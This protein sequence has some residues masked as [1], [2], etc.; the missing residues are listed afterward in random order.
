MTGPVRRLILQ[1]TP[2]CNIGCRYC[3]LPDRDTRQVMPMQVVAATAGLLARSARLDAAQLGPGLLDDQLE[4]RWH[5]GEPLTVPAAFY[6]QACQVLAD[7]LSPVTRPWFS[8]QTNGTLI[9]ASWCDLFLRR[10]IEVG[11]SIDGPAF[12]HDASRVTKRGGPTHARAMRGIAALRAAG[13]AFDVITVVTE[14]T[15]LHA[16]EY[17]DFMT[18]LRPR[19]IGLNPEETEGAHQSGLLGAS[20]F[21]ARYTEFLARMY[22]WQE[23]TGIPVRQLTAMRE[24][25]RHGRLPLRNDQAEPL[26]IVSVTVDGR[27]STF[28]PEL[29]GWSAPGYGDFAIGSVLDPGCSLRRWPAGFA[30]LAADIEAGV[31]RCAATCGYFGL[32]GG[33]APANKWAENHDFASTTTG[34]CQAATM[35]VADVVLAALEIEDV[36]QAGEG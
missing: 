6:A 11:V 27:V 17:L 16:D 2:F 33:G 21:R 15:L 14:A 13:I 12:L 23:A 1:P 19:S 18:G 34:A 4:I 35:A 31:R 30:R 5:A 26:M 10:G 20:S 28:S 9:D 32:C 3:Y 29:L 8:L 25:V 24:Q 7:A 22:A 36:R